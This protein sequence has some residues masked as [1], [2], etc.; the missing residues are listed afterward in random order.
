MESYIWVLLVLM[1]AETCAKIICLAVG[2]LPPRNP[3]ATAFDVLITCGLVAWGL[4]LV[5]R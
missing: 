3:I 4:V 2:F 5:I 1:I